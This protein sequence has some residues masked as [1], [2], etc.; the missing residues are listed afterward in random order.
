MSFKDRNRH[1]QVSYVLSKSL[2]LEFFVQ[3]DWNPLDWTCSDIHRKFNQNQHFFAFYF[4]QRQV[5]KVVFNDTWFFTDCIC[6]DKTE[7]LLRQEIKI[8]EIRGRSK[9]FSLASN[10]YIKITF[11]S[12]CACFVFLF[13][14]FFWLFLVSRIMIVLCS[15]F[16]LSFFSS[17]IFNFTDVLF[18]YV[19]ANGQFLYPTS[20]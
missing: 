13:V 5:C 17:K 6:K 15:F 19:L 16:S 4:W 18:Y 20:L 7:K 12:F 11:I 8:K 2:V 14:L 10:T 1:H 3:N 9:S